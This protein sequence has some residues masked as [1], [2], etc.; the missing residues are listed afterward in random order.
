MRVPSVGRRGTYPM[1]TFSLLYIVLAYTRR[2]GDDVW[3]IGTIRKVSWGASSLIACW[4]G[5]RRMWCMA[6]VVVVAFVRSDTPYTFPAVASSLVRG[7]RQAGPG[8]SFRPFL[9]YNLN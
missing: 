6:V 2:V 1:G 7:Y 8:K 3:G 5:N 9:D 4:R